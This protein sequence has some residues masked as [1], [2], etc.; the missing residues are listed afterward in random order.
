[1]EATP[2]L[3]LNLDAA[4]EA[5]G[6]SKSTLYL[7]VRSGRVSYTRIPRD[8]ARG[9]IYFTQAQLE[10]LFAMHEVR[11]TTS[12]PSTHRRRRLQAT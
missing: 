11:A 2:R 8:S 4:A 10:E 9:R 6:I 3:L 5:T 12:A 1:M 7:L